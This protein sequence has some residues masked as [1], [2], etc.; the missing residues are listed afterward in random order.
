[1]FVALKDLGDRYIDYRGAWL[2]ATIMGLVVFLVN[3]SHGFQ[4]ASVACMKQAT[5][6]FFF[7]GLITR[8]NEN[9][10]LMESNRWVAIV[11]AGSVSSSMAIGFTYLVHSLKGTPEPFLSTLPTMVIAPPAFIW[12]AWKRLAEEEG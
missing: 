3:L 9:L 5:Y 4:G 1:M 7:A 10:A 12:L 8:L 2:G 11:L 6:T